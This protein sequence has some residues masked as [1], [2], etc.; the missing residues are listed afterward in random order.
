MDNVN[1]DVFNERMRSTD[2]EITSISSKTEKLT[3]DIVDLKKITERITTLL[4]NTNERLK[5]LEDAKA[6]SVNFLDTDN[7][8]F[9]IKFIAFLIA[10]VV[11]FALFGKMIDANMFLN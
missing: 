9:L 11:V 3:E 7:G 10:T 5:T 2:R 6:S 4:E 1:K 8:K